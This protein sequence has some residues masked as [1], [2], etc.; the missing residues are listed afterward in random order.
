M[1]NLTYKIHTNIELELM[2]SEKKPFA[3]FS[4]EISALPDERIIPEEKFRAY[5]NEGKIVRDEFEIQGS[6]SKKLGR[7]AIIRHVVFA[8]PD[9]TWRIHAWK[10]L[11]VEF[12]TTNRWNETLERIQGSLLGYSDAENDEHCLILFHDADTE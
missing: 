1:H 12:G 4:D 5:I 6:Y 10:L 9:Q 2:I 8:L 7:P 3:A 11:C